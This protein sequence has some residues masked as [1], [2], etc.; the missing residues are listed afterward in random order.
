MWLL[1]EL[2]FLGHCFVCRRFSKCGSHTLCPTNPPS[3]V[4]LRSV[5]DSPART[6]LFSDK[7]R[8]LPE[9][10]EDSLAQSSLSSE[11][12]LLDLRKA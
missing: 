7:A 3:L 8:A 12:E 1:V 10:G 2:N 6:E 9:I 11:V 5:N 4:P